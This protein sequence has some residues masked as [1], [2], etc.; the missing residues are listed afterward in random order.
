MALATLFESGLSSQLLEYAVAD[1]LQK[2]D[3][4]FGTNGLVHD[5][6]ILDIGSGH[7]A[8]QGMSVHPVVLQENDGVIVIP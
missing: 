1:G 6:N 7:D 4:I 5:Y 8:F 3:W 2:A